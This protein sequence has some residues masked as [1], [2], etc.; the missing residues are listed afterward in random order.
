MSDNIKAFNVQLKRLA[1]L[2]PERALQIKRYI[3]LD[4]NAEIILGNPVNTGYSRANWRIAN[5][6]PDTA[7]TSKPA[8]GA[9]MTPQALNISAVQGMTLQAPTYITNSVGYVKFLEEG[10][11]KMAPRHFIKR[12]IQIVAVRMREYI[13]RAEGE[14]PQ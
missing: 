6:A 3:V 11:S 5:D 14:I 1:E 12:A 8:K 2:V 4:L 7:V 10:T 9:V 13:R